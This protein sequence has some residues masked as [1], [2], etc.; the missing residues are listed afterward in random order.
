MSPVSLGACGKERTGFPQV[1]DA[2]LSEIPHPV[3]PEI[4]KRYY[5]VYCGLDCCVIRTGWCDSYWIGG[6]GPY[7]GCFQARSVAKA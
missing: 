1:G 2:D 4:W 5:Y 3:D 6:D 7:L